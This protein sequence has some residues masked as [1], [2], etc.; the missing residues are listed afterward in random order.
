MTKKRKG[1]FKRVE[2]L[3]RQPQTV[4]LPLRIECTKTRAVI[5]GCIRILSYDENR[6]LLQT[7]DGAIGFEG[8]CLRISRMAGGAALV[9]G[10]FSAVRFE[11]DTVCG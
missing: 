1:T 6:I 3:L 10:K 2:Q 7:A 5:E 8:E 11:E 9:C 4:L